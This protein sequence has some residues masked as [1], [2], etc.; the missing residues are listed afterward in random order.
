MKIKIVPHTK[1]L[2]VRVGE[3]DPGFIR[4]VNR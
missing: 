1:E 3:D 4:S 2:R